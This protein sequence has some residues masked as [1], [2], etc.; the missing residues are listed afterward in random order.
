MDNDKSSDQ[1]PLDPIAPEPPNDEQ[2]RNW[3]LIL[4]GLLGLVIVIVLT[5]FYMMSDGETQDPQLESDSVLSLSVV[6]EKV[7]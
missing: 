5:F 6:K 3:L 7:I 2:K 4:V 1:H